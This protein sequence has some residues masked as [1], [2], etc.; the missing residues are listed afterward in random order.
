MQAGTGAIMTD[1]IEPLLKF[2]PFT[3]LNALLEGIKP[4][5]PVM[6][7]SVGE[8]QAQPPAFLAEV[9]ERE[10]KDWSRYPLTAGSPD[11]R[12]A[13]TDWLNRRFH[14]PANFIDR[15][16]DVLPSAGSKEALF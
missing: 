14:L 16:L 5:G 3:R 11:F 9:L 15:D 7:L 13:V 4:G 1:R 8:P 12:A 2:H 10:K 6:A